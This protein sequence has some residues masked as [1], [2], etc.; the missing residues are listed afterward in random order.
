MSEMQIAFLP[1]ALLFFAIAA[2]GWYLS[3]KYSSQILKWGAIALGG[4]LVLVIVASRLNPGPGPCD[5][6]P[7]E[8]FVA[9][10]IGEEQA[11]RA[12]DYEFYKR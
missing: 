3:F 2:A 10:S 5:N 6:V 1:V 9:C 12:D 4:V 8:E 7:D 11:Q